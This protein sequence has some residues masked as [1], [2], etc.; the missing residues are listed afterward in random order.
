MENGDELKQSAKVVLMGDSSVGKTAILKRF[1]D[2][3]FDE[4]GTPTVGAA[5]SNI[6]VQLENQSVDISVWDTAGQDSFRHIIPMYFYNSSVIIAVY[7]VTSKESF[8]NIPQWL[9]M[10]RERTSEKTKI[11]LV[12]NKID[13]EDSKRV[14][15]EEGRNYALENGFANFFEVSAKTNFNIDVL[16]KDVAYQTLLMPLDKESRVSVNESSKKSSGCC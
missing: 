10:A 5:C 12:G 2:S 13:L 7:D 4:F 14:E 3:T 15:T 16:L 1:E 9:E 11:I 8:K 6:T